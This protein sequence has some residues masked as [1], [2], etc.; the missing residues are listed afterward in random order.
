MNRQSDS[1][2][3]NNSLDFVL[4]LSKEKIDRHSRINRNTVDDLEYSVDDISND[5]ILGDFT[6]NS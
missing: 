2:Q 4:D 6:K 5:T 3:I 1:L